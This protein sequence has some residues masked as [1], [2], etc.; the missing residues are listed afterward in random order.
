MF[1]PL[2]DARPGQGALDFLRDNVPCA[3][4]SQPAFQPEPNFTD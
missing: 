1:G 4:E 2:P 3:I